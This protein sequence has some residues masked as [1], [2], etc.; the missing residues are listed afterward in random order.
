MYSIGETQVCVLALHDRHAHRKYR[1]AQHNIQAID[2]GNA[3]KLPIRQNQNLP[4][5]FG[6]CVA[7]YSAIFVEFPLPD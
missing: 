1:S 7:F 4:I 2:H 5:D 3:N 6:Y